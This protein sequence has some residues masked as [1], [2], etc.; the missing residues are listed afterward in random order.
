MCLT[1][2]SVNVTPLGNNKVDI[3]AS[4]RVGN[5]ARE[6]VL[7]R[8]RR[9][10]TLTLSITTAPV[11]DMCDEEVRCAFTGVEL[12]KQLDIPDGVR[13]IKVKTANGD[14]LETIKLD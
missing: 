13:T 2:L 1:N 14:V 8:R 7:R 11:A 9:G 10:A 12:Q 3:T 4:G 5:N 6:L